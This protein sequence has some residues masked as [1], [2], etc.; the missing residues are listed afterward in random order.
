[1]SDKLIDGF[2]AAYFTGI[3]GQSIGMFVFLDGKIAG[4]DAGGGRYDGTYAI[5]DDGQN[6]VADVR[7]SLSAGG[8]SITGV[9]SGAAPMSIPVKLM[10]PVD[11][12]PHQVHRLETPMGPV[13]AKFE[14][15][16]GA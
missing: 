6:I 7:F 5:S 1:M 4:A 11:L 8:M 16:R 13:N 14:K 12:Q 2:Y 10:L 9:T 3:A 15:V